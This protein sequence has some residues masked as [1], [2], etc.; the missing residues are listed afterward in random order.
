MSALYNSIKMGPKMPNKQRR[1]LLTVEETDDEVDLL[2]HS[3][4]K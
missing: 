1:L 4:M 3:E 2:P